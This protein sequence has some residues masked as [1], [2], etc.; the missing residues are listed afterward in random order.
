MLDRIIANILRLRGVHSASIHKNGETLATSFDH[1]TQAQLKEA[2]EIFEQIFSGLEAIGKTHNEV[3]FSL[4]DNYIAAF[5]MYNDHYA[6]LLMEKKVNFPLIKIGL[7]SASEK[8]KRQILQDKA[9][10]QKQQAIAAPEQTAQKTNAVAQ[11]SAEITPILEQYSTVLTLFMG[12]AAHF[13]VEDCA[14]E[15][16]KKYLQS[17]SN[18]EYLLALIQDELSS[19]EEKERFIQQIELIVKI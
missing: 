16:K 9:D 15:W 13:V 14:T 3:Y 11:T 6:I 12:P 18:L 7:K 19:E 8:I 2:I 17:T 4:E 10:Q 5:R 1:S